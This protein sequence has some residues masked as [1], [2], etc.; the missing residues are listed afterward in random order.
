MKE[1]QDSSWPNAVRTRVLNSTTIAIAALAL[2]GAQTSPSAVAETKPTTVASFDVE[3]QYQ[4]INND[5][6]EMHDAKLFAAQERAE[7]VVI[8]RAPEAARSVGHKAVT[9]CI[10]IDPSRLHHTLPKF[11]PNIQL[12]CELA[13]NEPWAKQNFKAQLEALIYN[14]WDPESGMDPLADNPGSSAHGIP[15]AL[16]GKKMGPGWQDNAEAQIKW[17]LN[18][19]DKRYGSP[20][21]AV[22]ARQ[23]KGYY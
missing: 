3:T 20:L 1:K 14:I 19:I 6:A 10:K 8:P 23:T 17:G 5:L 11:Y 22:H 7:H 21:G 4:S 15:Q 12:T 13:K 16:P 9:E 2:V 18:Y